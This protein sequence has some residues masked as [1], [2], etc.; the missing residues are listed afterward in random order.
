MIWVEGRIVG[1]EELHISALDR[2]FE[3]GLGLFETL[4]T[5]GGHPTLLPRHLDRLMRSGRMLDLEID[6]SSLPDAPAVASLLAADGRAGDAVLR[7][8]AS[9]GDPSTRRPVVWMRSAELPMMAGTA[10]CRLELIG[11]GP[12][13]EHKSLN[14]LERREAFQRAQSG[15]WDETLRCTADGEIREGSRTSIFAVRGGRVWTPPLR[16]AASTPGGWGKS[17]EVRPGRQ[18]GPSPIVPGVMRRLVIEQAAMMGVSVVEDILQVN[19]VPEYEEMLL[20]N[21]VRGIQ[22]VSRVG[23][24]VL[25]A[26]GP[27]TTCLWSALR[28][29]LESGE[30]DR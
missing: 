1:D 8:T 29:R 14:Y 3:H 26:P 24:V 19:E 11:G 4:R 23:E 12:L 13:D 21:S 18:P 25:D 7:I 6:S 10:T 2:T 17:P 27:L 28:T 16:G 15:G 9:G 5:W 30:I 22:P 20:T